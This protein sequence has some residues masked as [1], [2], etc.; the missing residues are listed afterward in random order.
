M[1]DRN[2]IALATL[3]VILGG[4]LVGILDAACTPA[5]GPGVSALGSCILIRSV[6]D[7]EIRPPMT[8][9]AIVEDTSGYC[10]TD[11]PT[12]VSTLTALKDEKARQ[13]KDAGK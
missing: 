12:V 11:V 4:A 3:L 1:T 9:L 6:T 7:A 13:T 8:A 10:A 5:T 2:G